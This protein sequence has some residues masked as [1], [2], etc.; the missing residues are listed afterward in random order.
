MLK[1]VSWGVI[2]GVC[3][4]LVPAY[5]CYA[6]SQSGKVSFYTEGSS[7]ASG[8]RFNKRALTCAHRTIP[9]GTIVT[10]GY[11]GKVVSCRVNDRGPA[12]WTGRM[13]DLSLASA[14]ALGMTKAGVVYATME[15]AA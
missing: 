3:M 15:W 2:L 5:P 6:Q 9:F 10:V 14:Q 7:T 8:E 13:L 12:K 4:I 1:I 11:R